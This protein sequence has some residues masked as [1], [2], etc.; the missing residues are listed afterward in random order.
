[1]WVHSW[2]GKCSPLERGQSQF[3]YVL[4]VLSQGKLIKDVN[5]YPLGLCGYLI[6]CPMQNSR[7]TAIFVSSQF[8]PQLG[9]TIS[10]SNPPL[11]DGETFCTEQEGP[12]DNISN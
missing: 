7:D 1:M 4:N 6:S 3:V 2:A 11:L 5:M 10:Q 8:Q 9:R 12:E